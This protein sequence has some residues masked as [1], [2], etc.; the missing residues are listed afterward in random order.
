MMRSQHK[1]M[2][3][4]KYAVCKHLHEV[5]CHKA[6]SEINLV[7][8][9]FLEIS[10]SSLP[11]CHS[12]LKFLLGRLEQNDPRIKFKVSVIFTFL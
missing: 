6:C 1:A 12:L 8:N 7:Y 10:K 9:V 2:F 3:F 4:K 5:M 11:N